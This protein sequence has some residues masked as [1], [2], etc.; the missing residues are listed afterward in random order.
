MSDVLVN[1]LGAEVS[2]REGQEQDA[3]LERLKALEE[4]NKARIPGNQVTADDI[5][6]ILAGQPAATPQDGPEELVL[7]G[8][9]YSFASKA[10]MQKQL[11]TWYQQTQAQLAARPQA[12]PVQAAP[13][14]PVGFSEEKFEELLKE[15]D[16][17]KALLYAMQ[18]TL[19]GEEIA[20]LKR[21]NEVLLMRETARDVKAAIPAFQ[22]KTQAEIDVVDQ[23]RQRL[24]GRADN[25]EA[26]RAAVILAA[27]DGKIKL[28]APQATPAP[29]RNVVTPPYLGSTAAEPSVALEDYNR[30]LYELPFDQLEALARSRAAL[31]KARS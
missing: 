5:N 6:R 19:F 11:D 18:N 21:Q 2:G 24:G 12:A 17:R 26:W 8:Q 31:S 13:Q 15:K 14:E 10:D 30:R 27:N 23:Y 3:I 20:S 22:P 28:D 9:K 25:P 4:S 29:E 1:Q 7:G 16:P